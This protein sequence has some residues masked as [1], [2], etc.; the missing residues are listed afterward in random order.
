MMIDR[1]DGLMADEMRTDLVVQT[2]QAIDNT[3][4]LGSNRPA[5]AK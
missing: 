1:R 2:P 3:L 5:P 4:Y